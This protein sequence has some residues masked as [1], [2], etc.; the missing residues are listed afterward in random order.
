M[1]I[2]ALPGVASA[3]SRPLALG[4]QDFDFTQTHFDRVKASGAGVV[5]INVSWRGVAPTN[6]PA[7]FNPASPFEPS[8]K[9]EPYDTYVRAAVATGLQ[10]LVTVEQAAAYAERDKSGSPGTGNP[11]PVQF[12]LFGEA[13]ARRYSGAIAGLPRVR[14]FEAWNEPN[15]NFFLHPQRAPDGR[16]TS[17]GLYRELVNQFSAGVHR[18]HQ[19]NIVVAGATFPFTI[20]R[21]SGVS[22]GP[23]RFLREVLCLSEK[24]AV[25]PACGPPVQFDVL[26]HHP[27]TSGG[28]THRAGSSDSISLGDMERLGRLLKAA[29][30]KGR[31]SSRAPVRFWVTEFGWDS[32]PADPKGVPAALH[33]RWVS[34]A[35]YR[36]WR[37]GVSLFVWYR[38]RD[39]PAAGAVQS[40]LW[41]RCEAGIAC[42]KPK[43]ASLQAFRFPFVAF[44]S[45]KRVDV[46]GRVPG[47]VRARV[48]VERKRK[49][50][51]RRLRV[52]RADT[53][54]IFGARLR[55][56][57]KGSL[58]A[59]VLSTKEASV[60]FSL[61]RVRDR[62]FNPFGST[63]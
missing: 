29:V 24:L 8:Y 40:G 37:A 42:D 55:G 34:E 45:R 9:W 61:K 11:D 32:A 1:V 14:M 52:L 49:G 21:A 16:T 10:P 53:A 22:I 54:G 35:L 2:L 51:W 30:R 7:A 18:V 27:Y 63:G 19:D 36:S 59:Q 12:G 13:V 33:A 62:P 28:P 56:P 20:N 26:S 5:K 23:Y 41:F 4:L 25:V 3:A 15:A 17:P 38:L 48:A 43:T 50:K 44:R 39:G 46:W 60:P 57:R 6:P 31:I 58:R 47:G